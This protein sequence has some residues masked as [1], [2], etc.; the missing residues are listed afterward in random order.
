MS[1]AQLVFLTSLV[2]LVRG[3][4]T[5]KVERKAKTLIGAAFDTFF[6]VAVVLLVV[7][8]AKHRQEFAFYFQ[9]EY[10]RIWIQNNLGTFVFCLAAIVL[11]VAFRLALLRE[12]TPSFLKNA[13]E[14]LD[15]FMMAGTIALIL[16]TY[17]VRTYY[18]PSESMAPTLEVHDYIIVAKP[19]V[20][21]LFHDFPPRRGDIVVFHPPLPGENREFIKRVIGLPGETLYVHD[22][23]VFINGKP[24][25][26]PYIKAP[27]DYV[28]GPI[29]IPAKNYL[30]FGDNRRN[31]EDSHAWP[32]VGATP[33]LSLSRIEG[34]AV[35]IFL[36]PNHFHIFRL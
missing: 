36:P 21:K 5:L 7:L 10:I 4:F 26:E 32:E 19:F 1:A 22:G 11:L 12:W 20:L 9:Q 2:A 24:L 3:L 31:S 17:F 28:F 27:P 16:I 8:Y 29:T 25:T 13:Y 23:K 34:T 15:P 33:F 35:T 6:A 18:I 30:V 14:W